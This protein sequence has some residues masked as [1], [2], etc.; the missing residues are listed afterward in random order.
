M[1]FVI[2]VH[3]AAGG[4]RGQ[5]VAVATGLARM[6]DNLRDAL[7]FIETQIDREDPPPEDGA[8]DED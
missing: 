2:R 5:V 4:V 1:A 7:A 6:F 3:R 8:R